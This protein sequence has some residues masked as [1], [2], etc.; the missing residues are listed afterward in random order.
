[1]S[2]SAAAACRSIRRSSAKICPDGAP[3]LPGPPNHGIAPP[4]IDKVDAQ[5]HDS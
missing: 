3:D 5:R 2:A 4:V 1:M